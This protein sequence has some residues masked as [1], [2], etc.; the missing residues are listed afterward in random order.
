M[1]IAL[2][3]IGGGALLLAAWAGVWLSGLTPA[4]VAAE[5][6]ASI[7]VV[8]D[9]NYPPFVFRG[10]D[11][12]LQGIL[13]DQWDLWEEKTGIKVDCIGMVWFMA[14]KKMEAGDY[15]VIDTIFRTEKREKNLVFT[16]PYATLDVPVFHHRKLPGITGLDA[17]KTIP[18]AAKQGDTGLDLLK[19]KG[20]TNLVVFHSYED[21]ILAAANEKVVAFVMDKP[22]ALYFLN[23]HRLA[24]QFKMLSP[25]GS[26][27]FHRAVKKGREDLLKT[28]EEG[29]ASISPRAYAALERKWSGGPALKAEY[30]WYAGAGLALVLAGVAG[31][32]AWNRSL[33]RAVAEQ[34]ARL[35]AE[36]TLSRERERALLES[37]EKF[38]LFIEHFPGMVFIKDSSFQTVL[39]SKSFEKFLGRPHAEMIGRTNRD[40]FPAELAEQ[41]DRDDR[42]A[43][44]LS[45]GQHA[46]FEET[47]GERVYLTYKFPVAH[48]SQKMI[49]GFTI[50]I[51]ERKRGDAERRKL[52]AQIQHTQKLESLGVLAGGIAHDFNNLLTVILGNIDLAQASLPPSAPARRSLTEA[53]NASR[54]A[55]DLCRQ[56]L[57][58][59]GKG[60]VATELL[61]LN[62]LLRDMVSMIEI[63]ISKS[64]TLRWQL[65]PTLPPVSADRSQIHQIVMNLLINASEAMGGQAGTITLA[66]GDAHCTREE[67]ADP[68]QHDPLPEGRY[69][70]IEVADTGCG[71]A[72][73]TLTR[74][75]D[76]FFSTKFTGRGLGLAAVQGIVRTHQGVVTVRSQPARGT[77]FR[78]LLPAANGHVPATTRDPGPGQPWRGRGTV[79]LVDD[80]DGVR[81][82]AR[83][84]LQRFGYEVLTAAHGLEALDVFRVN[85]D[86]ISLV[87]LDLTMPRMDGETTLRELLRI[88]RDVRVVLSSGYDGHDVIERLGREG[89]AGFVQKPYSHEN[90]AAVLQQAT[91][92]AMGTG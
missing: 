5:K 86:R 15:D 59:A 32:L 56:M 17:L 2:R 68:W 52:E 73:E 48:R 41:F 14:L 70:F 75:F 46:E 1:P 65:T 87:L 76:P 21:I 89:M 42:E 7:R 23:K 20:F 53:T 90:L 22:P 3:R 82:V 29:F 66:T 69:V 72:P 64:A 84:M 55:A 60:R 37:E 34:T 61:D 57:A 49:G 44:A 13:I 11:G 85:P 80:E 79:L 27:Q 6:P 24:E 78:I 19:E 36:V 18:V 33:R 30:L 81:E 26:G 58:Y 51:T 25:L 45:Y 71:M 40:L 92:V 47:F 74:I 43:L 50:D 88:R 83:Q 38:R 77:T 35:Q 9:D 4:G 67:L 28:V 10:G 62:Q 91:R 39:L 54:R 63:S 31:L 8:M 12:R 16:K